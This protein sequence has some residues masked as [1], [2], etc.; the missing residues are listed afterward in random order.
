MSRPLLVAVLLPSLVQV[1]AWQQTPGNASPIAPTAPADPAAVTFSTDVGL[2]LVAVKPDKVADYEAAVVGLQEVLS[3]A[4]DETARRVASGWR[5]YKAADG[6][7]KANVLYVHVLQPTV[8]D[9]DYRPSL[10][11]DKLMAGAP[12]ELLAKYRDAFALPPSKL[13]LSEFAD[14]SVAPVP[15]PTNASPSAPDAP[16]SVNKSPSGPAPP[17]KR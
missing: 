11:L 4:E 9:A 3:K 5:V 2:L 6:D 1:P 17:K 10:W 16:P 14:M 7:T 13:S 12:A 8:P 15:K